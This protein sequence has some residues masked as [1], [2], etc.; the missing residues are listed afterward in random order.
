MFPLIH[1]IKLP[2]QRTT[3]CAIELL[4]VAGGP[5][6][7]TIWSI[8]NSNEKAETE[9]LSAWTHMPWKASRSSG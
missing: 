7:I 5:I 9:P 3:Y 6:P 1:N 4:V 2:E 8:G